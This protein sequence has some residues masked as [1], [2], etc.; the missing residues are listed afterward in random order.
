MKMKEISDLALAS[1]LSSIGHK[2]ISVTP[3]A[4]RKLVFVFENSEK[5]QND[6]LNFVNRRG[7]V[8]ALTFFE[9]F[10]NLK[11]LTK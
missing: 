6:T 3:T 9:T 11:A 2:I 8:D 7:Q 5:L 10:R 1:Y 4:T